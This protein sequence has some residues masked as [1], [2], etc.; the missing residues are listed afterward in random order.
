MLGLTATAQKWAWSAGGK[1]P[2]A[3]DFLR[4]GQANA[5]GTRLSDWVDKGFNGLGTDLKSGRPPRFWRFWARGGGKN[6]LV[7]GVLRDS[8][9][10]VGRVYPFLVV[11]SGGLPGWEEQWDLLPYGCET[12]WKRIEYLCTKSYADVAGIERELL[13]MR[14]PLC[15]WRD[16][17]A[18]RDAAACRRLDG[19]DL[20]RAA[21]VAGEQM[22]V[23]LDQG[24][25]DPLFT[26]GLLLKRIREGRKV[27]PNLVFIGG[28]A[29]NSFLSIFWRPLLAGDFAALWG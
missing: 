17:S 4:I 22:T 1:H 29:D 10:S 11:G 13:A 2:A 14:P 21:G 6:D 7:C 19:T 25:A 8:C 28:T 23:A 27:P 18:I 26:V 12:T 16:F 9:D 5:I 24:A 3:R 15:D 20:L